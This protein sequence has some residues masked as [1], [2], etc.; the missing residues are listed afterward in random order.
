RAGATM[1]EL[2]DET[3]AL[4]RTMASRFRP[5]ATPIL[6]EPCDLSG[7][8]LRMTVAEAFE[9]F[10]NIDEERMLHL[11]DHDEDGFY[12]LLVEGVEPALATLGVPVLLHL[13]P[14]PQASLARLHPPDRRYAERFELYVADLE[15]CNGF[16][17]LVDP[18]E[19][20]QRLERDRRERDAA[21]LPVYPIDEGFLAALAEGLP[22]CA[23]NALG[24]DRL[25]ALCL[26]A[27][28]VAD[29]MAFPRQAL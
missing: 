11:A 2:M 29:V 20:R 24:L 5:V 18:V 14:A 6:A 22:P 21:G 26:G 3:E 28:R 15:L 25:V 13:Y 10:A 17:E 7:P 23:G 9:R 16:G 1:T 8:F 19:Q 4:V 12:R 27:P